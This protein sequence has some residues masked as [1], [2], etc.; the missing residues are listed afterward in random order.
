MSARRNIVRILRNDRRG[1]IAIITALVSLTLVFVLGVGVDYGLAVDRKAQLETYADAAALAA[2]TPAMVAAG[3]TAAIT[4]AENVFNAQ[5]LSLGG[6]DYNASGVTVSISANGNLQT[7]TVQYQAKSNSILPGIMG[8]SGIEI[9][10]QATATTT[11]APNIDFYLLLDDSPSMAIAATQAG[12]D[13]MVANTSSQGGCAFGCHEQAP[14]N[15]GLQEDNYALARSLGVTL[16]IDTLRQATQDL[17]TTA[18]NTENQNGST[19]RMA[20]YTFDVGLNS[21]EPL[22]SDLTQAQTEASNI[23]QLEVYSNN[24]LTSSYNNDDEDTD[25]DTA[26]NGINAI[27]PNPGNGTRTYGD[28]PQ[29]VLFFVTDGVE[30]ENVNGGRQQSVLNATLCSN[31]KSRGIR[32]AVLYTEYLPLPTNSWYNTYIAP[33]QS[34]ISPTLQQCASPGLYFEVQTGGD[35]SAAMSALFNSAVQ[36]SYLSK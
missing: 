14:W 26:L 17:M 31:I 20:I 12:I 33:F 18:Q 23:Q 3:Q 7:A 5:A 36:S 15:D 16:R 8:S 32:I 19:Y 25:Y 2:V 6:I 11:L 29:E 1:N 27:M 28:T 24:W 10:G 22:T 30:D 21:I 35:I 9:G 4:K 34:N 13:T